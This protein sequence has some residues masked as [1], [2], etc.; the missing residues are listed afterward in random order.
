MYHLSVSEID[1]Y[2]GCRSGA[3]VGSREEDEVSG[4]GVICRYPVAFIAESLCGLSSDIGIS[5]VV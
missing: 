3:F 2:V 5:A 1:A 4:L